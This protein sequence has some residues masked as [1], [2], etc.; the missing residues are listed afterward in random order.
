MTQGLRFL[1]LGFGASTIVTSFFMRLHPAHFW[2]GVV[3]VIA[4]NAWTSMGS[5]KSAP[6]TPPKG[7][8]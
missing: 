1:L 3:C 8:P 2:F 5:V 7:R 4:W 6:S